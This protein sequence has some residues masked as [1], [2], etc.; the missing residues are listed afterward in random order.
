MTELIWLQLWRGGGNISGTEIGA[1]KEKS[2]GVCDARR[3]GSFLFPN[4][5]NYTN[6][7]EERDDSFARNLV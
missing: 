5:I 2:N 3:G 6:I 4:I 7:V 1:A